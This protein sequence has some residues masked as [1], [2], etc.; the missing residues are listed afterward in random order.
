MHPLNL[1]PYLKLTHSQSSNMRIT[2]AST[3]ASHTTNLTSATKLSSSNHSAPSAP[4]L[5]D[6]LRSKLSGPSDL[7]AATTSPHTHLESLTSTHPLEAR[8]KHWRATQHNLKMEG[9]RRQF[10]MAEPIR[11]GM[12][13][14]IVREGEY[15]AGVLGGSAGVHGDILEGRDERIEWEDIYGGDETVEGAGMHAEMEAR[16]RMSQ[17]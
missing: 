1:R 2:P 12:E 6:T 17:M 11:R 16:V 7:A 4:G 5:H 13:L 10:G 8:L 9:L 15:R 3:H 14:A